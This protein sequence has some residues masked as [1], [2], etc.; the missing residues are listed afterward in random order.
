MDTTVRSVQP[1]RHAAQVL[2]LVQCCMAD[3]AVKPSR[4][5]GARLPNFTLRNVVTGKQDTLYSQAEPKATVVVF[6]SAVC[7]CSQGYDA[8]MAALAQEYRQRGVRFVGINAGEGETVAAAAEHATRSDLSFPVLKDP[9]Q[10]V[11]ARLGARM[12]PEVYVADSLG[13]VRYHGR[14]DDNRDAA[15]VRRHDLQEA[16]DGLLSGKRPERA[17]VTPFGCAIPRVVENPPPVPGSTASL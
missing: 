16:L 11:M 13:I 15:Q 12:T 1:S 2:P 5:L 3:F 4:A 14:I 10:V 8:R 6:L 17:D 9:K 7:P